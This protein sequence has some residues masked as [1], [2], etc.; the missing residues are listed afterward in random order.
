MLHFLLVITESVTD[1]DI[2]RKDMEV[3]HDTLDYIVKCIPKTFFLAEYLPHPNHTLQE[4]QSL[5][6]Q[7][8]CGTEEQGA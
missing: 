4:K 6:L 8:I 7:N 3:P 2:P 5:L 1:H